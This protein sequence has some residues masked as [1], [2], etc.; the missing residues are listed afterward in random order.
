MHDDTNRSTPLRADAILLIDEGPLRDKVVRCAE[1]MGIPARA[2]SASDE[3]AALLQGASTP[4]LIVS[5]HLADRVPEQGD[6]LSSLAPVILLIAEN[7]EEHLARPIAPFLVV[8]EPEEAEGLA[9]AVT[10]A[11]GEAV[12]VAEDLHEIQDHYERL[13]SLSTE[14]RQVMEAVCSGMLNKQIAREYGVSI[15][16]IEQRRRRLFNKMEVL[17]AVPLASHVASVRTLERL[18]G[19][20]ARPIDCEQPRTLGVIPIAPAGEQG[21]ASGGMLAGS[22]LMASS[23]T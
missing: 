1:S 20:R 4:L 8:G 11:A 10:L 17:S 2:T 18:H 3:C 19:R 12:R 21:D 15:R 5:C 13:A 7:A 22:S 23:M 6:A 9:S 14:E 16:T